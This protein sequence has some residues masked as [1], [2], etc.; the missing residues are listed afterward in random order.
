MQGKT[1]TAFTIKTPF[2]P[3]G[4]YNGRT[5]TYFVSRPKKKLRIT[6][7]GETPREN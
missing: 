6:Y 4:F 5:L 2:R 1:Y 3:F 7:R